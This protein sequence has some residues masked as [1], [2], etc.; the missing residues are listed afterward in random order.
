[1]SCFFCN[2]DNAMCKRYA[3]VFCAIYVD[4]CDLESSVEILALS[5]MFILLKNR[6][7]FLSLRRHGYDEGLSDFCVKSCVS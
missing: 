4:S 1:M 3:E 7:P 2:F 5:I 6:S